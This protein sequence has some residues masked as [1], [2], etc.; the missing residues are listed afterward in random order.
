MN[1][2]A[3]KLHPKKN[4][5]VPLERAFS[6]LGIASRTQARKLIT[7]GRVSVDEKRCTDPAALVCPETA[8][9]SLDGKKMETNNKSM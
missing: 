1:S 9:I 2:K 3:D 6:K 5:N 4:G 7:A 8:K